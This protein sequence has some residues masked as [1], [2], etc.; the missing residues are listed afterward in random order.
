MKEQ[1]VLTAPAGGAPEKDR[2]FLRK[3]RAKRIVPKVVLYLILSLLALAWLI[4]FLFAL[5]TSFAYQYNRVD[6]ENV[7]GIYHKD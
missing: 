3:Q 5:S 2:A 4:P 1:I 7:I 6:G